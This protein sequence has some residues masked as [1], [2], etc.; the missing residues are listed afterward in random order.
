MA[1]GVCY[2]L[3][4]CARL[5]SSTVEQ[6]RRLHT[7]Y[8]CILAIDRG[9]MHQQTI[10]EAD[11]HGSRVFGRSSKIYKAVTGAVSQLQ[12]VT[13]ACWNV[14]TPLLCSMPATQV[15]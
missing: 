9:Y 7:V 1:L 5:P 4:H 11:S 8:V 3:L 15:K 10:A 2:L 14:E 6:R 12:R 13:K